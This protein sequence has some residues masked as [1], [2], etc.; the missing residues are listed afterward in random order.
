MLRVQRSIYFAIL[1]TSDSVDTGKRFRVA[2]NR[3][4]AFFGRTCGR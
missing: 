1:A 2:M 3:H 4:N